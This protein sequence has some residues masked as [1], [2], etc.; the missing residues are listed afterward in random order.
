MKRRSRFIFLAITILL[1]L[2]AL[3]GILHPGFFLSDDGNWMVIRFSA[4]YESLRNGQFPVRFLSRLNYGYG[5]P[6]ADFLYPLF[7]YLG[8]PI[9]ALGFS[10]VSTIKIIFAASMILSSIFSFLWLRRFFDNIP[11]L[12]G[13]LVYAYA[14][15]HLFNLYNRG[16]IGE[17]LAL[18]IIPFIFWQ[19]ERNSLIWSAIGISLLILSHNTLAVLFLSVVLLYMF[20]NIFTAARNRRILIY[21]YTSILAL[22]LALSAFFWI[23]AI[24]DLQYTVFS[25]TQISDWNKYFSD[26]SLI[27]FTAVFVIILTLVLTLIG[28]IEV[29][30]HKITSLFFIICIASI[31]FASSISA[32]FWNILPVS[33]IQFPFRFLSLTILCISFLVA[34]SVSVVKNTTRL[35]MVITV[36]FLTLVSAWPFL[37]PTSYQYHPDSFYSTNQDSTTVKNEYMPKWVKNL[38][39]SYD[40]KAEVLDGQE[41]L[42][43]LEVNLNKISIQAY[44]PVRRV[45][46]V[47]TVYFP[48][49]NAV[50]NGKSAPIDYTSNGL[51]RI[52]VPYGSSNI[53]VK[54]SETPIRAFADIIS[55]VGLLLVFILLVRR[56]Y[57]KS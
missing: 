46:Q 1:T 40:S 6:V 7:M 20:F 2:P 28:K 41:K 30:K 21:Q 11:S 49:W 23:P 39:N 14:P 53:D 42:N 57:K 25:K 22:G 27:G 8:V 54:F 19:I 32:G 47:N 18:A 48:G 10:F 5:Y 17:V 24:Y 44:L 52:D 45:I 16:S 31:F 38:P 43:I 13:S 55:I 15:Y 51:I 37:F 50:V 29:K 3:W 56:K 9:Y 26:V 33:F 35:V 12:V 36:F 4:F 34:C